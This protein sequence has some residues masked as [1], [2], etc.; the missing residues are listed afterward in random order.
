VL[1][2][3][4]DVAKSFGDTVVLPSLSLDVAAGELVGVIGPNGAGKSTMFGLVTGILACD[5]GQIL[6]AGRDM[7]RVPADARCRMG[8]G[9]TFQ[10]P[11]PFLGMTCFE[12]ALVAARFGGGLDRHA[13]GARAM[14]VLA[15]CGLA[16]L[17]NANVAGLTLLQ[18][19]RLEL[20]RALA[21]GPQ[22]LLLDEVGGGLTDP[23]VAELIELIA[24]IHAQGV[25]VVWVEHLVHALVSVVQRL[26]VL[27]EGRLLCDGIPQQ[28]MARPDVIETYLGSDLEIAK[29][30]ASA[31]HL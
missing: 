22:L 4:R 28:V 29:E 20:A 13:A 3:L 25:T 6:F 2:E 24:R 5:S 18:L 1:L 15:D 7:T 26:I 30:G 16:H 23:E 31:A 10:V 17:A 27:C 21:S 19:K 9:R 11:H 14:D 8:I 12:T